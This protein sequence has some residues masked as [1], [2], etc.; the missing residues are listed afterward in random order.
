M[1][2]GKTQQALKILCVGVWGEEFETLRAQGHIVDRDEVPDHYDLIMGP[3]CW[4]LRPEL[5]KYLPLALKEAR[6]A[7]GKLTRARKV[8]T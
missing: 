8:A 1:P 3:T 4:R 7:K 6:A 2:M 5:V